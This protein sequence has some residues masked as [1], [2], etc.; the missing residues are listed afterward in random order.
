MAGRADVR[1]NALDA[2]SVVARRGSGGACQTHTDPEAE[3]DGPGADVI[4][5][6]LR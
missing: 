4:R 3:V 5:E 2:P 1:A 6:R